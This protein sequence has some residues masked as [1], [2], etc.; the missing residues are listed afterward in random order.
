M[1]ERLGLESVQKGVKE[2]GESRGQENLFSTEPCIILTLLKFLGYLTPIPRQ[3]AIFRDNF[4]CHN[5]SEG[6]YGHLVRR[7]W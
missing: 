1:T 5:R 2:R 7:S 3:L 4:Y 6:C